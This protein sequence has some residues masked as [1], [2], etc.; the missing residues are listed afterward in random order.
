MTYDPRVLSLAALLL[1]AAMAYL[2][3]QKRDE[4][5]QQC[6]VSD[7]GDT[8]VHGYMQ[9]TGRTVAYLVDDLDYPYIEDRNEQFVEP[10]NV[11]KK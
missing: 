6:R 5:A 2:L 1:L 11:T 8:T 3:T 10:S 9:A 4:G 7:T